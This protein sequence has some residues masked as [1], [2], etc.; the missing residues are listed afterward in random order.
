MARSG[1]AV[2]RVAV[3]CGGAAWRVVVLRCCVWRCCVAC[4]GVV[5]LRVA[6]LRG[7]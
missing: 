1:V 5:V 3:Q 4:S 6:V 7:V 2:L